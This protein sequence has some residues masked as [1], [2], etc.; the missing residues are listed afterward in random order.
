MAKDTTAKGKDPA[1]PD[2]EAAAAK[3]AEE[4]ENFGTGGAARDGEPN[5]EGLSAEQRDELAKRRAARG[6]DSQE[7]EPDAGIGEEDDGQFFVWERG[8]KVTL[9][10]LIARGTPVEHA[11]VFGGKR[12][13]GQG[14]LMGFDE[15]PLMIVR[16]KPGPVKIVPTYDS[17]EEKV[18]KVTIESHVNAIIVQNADSEDGLALIAHVLDAHGYE[19]KASAA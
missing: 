6:V 2:A 12:T 1:G 18:T 7:P 9:G 5:G 10:T 19:K 3:A 14:G 4:S 13:K 15:K 16:G 8:R 17:D 11:F